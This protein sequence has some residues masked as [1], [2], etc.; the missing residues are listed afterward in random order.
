MKKF[1]LLLTLLLVA[2]VGHARVVTWTYSKDF[3]GGVLETTTNGATIK[4]TPGKVNTNIYVQNDHIRLYATGTFTI[5]IS[6]GTFNSITINYYKKETTNTISTPG[7]TIDNSQIN[8]TAFN[9]ATWT[10]AG[11]EQ[12]VTFTVDAKVTEDDGKVFFSGQARINSIVVNYTAATE[13]ADP[14]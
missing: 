11:D 7:G 1:Y 12:S 6:S 4:F 5:S 9:E 3:P 2:F 13:C 8:T 14:T 10:P